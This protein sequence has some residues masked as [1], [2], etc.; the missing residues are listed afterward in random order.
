MI[1]EV[2][3]PLEEITNR[4]SLRE[5]AGIFLVHGFLTFVAAAL[6]CVQWAFSEKGESTFAKSRLVRFGINRTAMAEEEDS[7]E[8]HSPALTRTSGESDCQG[9][10]SLV[11]GRGLLKRK[12]DSEAA[13]YSEASPS[14]EVSIHE[15]QTDPGWKESGIR[16]EASV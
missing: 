3:N 4:L 6:A 11:I 15:P 8:T 12:E 9:S 2:E 1:V 14:H 16:F 13:D 7:Y 10:S 5:M